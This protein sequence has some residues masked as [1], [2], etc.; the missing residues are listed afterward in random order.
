MQHQSQQQPE[1][2][3][4]RQVA[5]PVSS[6]DYLKDFQRGY[7]RA[8]GVRITNN[9]AL[10]LILAEHKSNVA[11]EALNEPARSTHRA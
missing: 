4:F 7:E 10:A 1:Q 2:L 9:Q 6:F 3:V 11:S 8:H 5:F